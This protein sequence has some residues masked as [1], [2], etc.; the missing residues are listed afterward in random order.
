MLCYSMLFG[1][2]IGTAYT[3]PVVLLFPRLSYLGGGGHISTCRGWGSGHIRAWRGCSR[4]VRG[5][6]QH[7]PAAAARV[8]V[9]D[10]PPSSSLTQDS[11]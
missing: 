5:C 6:D 9:T 1:I 3:G 7:P 10:T 4:G 2:A 8:D 11:R